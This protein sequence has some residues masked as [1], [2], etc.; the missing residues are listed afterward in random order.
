M[1]SNDEGCT[2]EFPHTEDASMTLKAAMITLKA[3]DTA[4][5]TLEIALVAMTSCRD[6]YLL[7][8]DEL[9]RQRYADVAALKALGTVRDANHVTGYIDGRWHYFE[10]PRVVLRLRDC[11]KR[12]ID[13]RAVV[14]A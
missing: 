1:S 12:C 5:K 14:E 6:G 7:E 8:H 9:V 4:M 13:A 2:E 10:C 3:R 11:D